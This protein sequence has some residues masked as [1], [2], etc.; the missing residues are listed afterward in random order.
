MTVPTINKMVKVYA[1]SALVERLKCGRPSVSTV[2]N[3]MTGVRAFLRWLSGECGVLSAECDVPCALCGEGD[4]EQSTMYN[5]QSTEVS[6]AIVKPKLVHRY[7]AHL[8]KKN[9]NPI[10]AMSNVYQFRQLFAKWV[11]PYYEDHGWK[12]PQFPSF[13]KRSRAPRYNRPSPE[14][15]AKVKIW[16]EGLCAE[17]GGGSAECGVLCAECGGGSAE[18]GGGSAE[19][20]GRVFRGRRRNVSARELWFAATM[21]LEFAM[22]NGDIMRLT[23]KNFIVKEDKHYLNYTPNKTVHS[24]GRVVKW[25]IHPRIWS[26]LSR[27]DSAL[28]TR[29]SALNLPALDDEVFDAL[30]REMRLLGF[31]G[32]KG[33]Y[34]LRKICIDHIYQRFG[35]ELAVSIS[36]DDIRTIMHYYADPAQPNIGEVCVVDLL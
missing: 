32:T 12:V 29:H 14:Q 31:T 17:C 2:R 3:T 28:G 13:G 23:S 24:S 34:E 22:R 7:L 1:D 4:P 11:L 16:Y 26:L 25:P 30:N 18:C 6:V 36:G 8:L 35:A 20:G 5:A 33:A 21:M 15:L 9:V 27:S 19:K 10:T